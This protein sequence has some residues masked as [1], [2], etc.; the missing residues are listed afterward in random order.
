MGYLHYIN[1]AIIAQGAALAY[2][3]YDARYVP[4]EQSA[5][6]AAQPRSSYCVRR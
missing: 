5:A 1:Q 2:P 6:L 4:F 3:R